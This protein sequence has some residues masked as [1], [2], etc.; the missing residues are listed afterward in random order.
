LQIYAKLNP[1][2]TGLRSLFLPVFSV[3]SDL[4]IVFL[5]DRPL[6]LAGEKL[7]FI[8][9]DYDRVVDA[10]LDTLRP[11]LLHGHLLVMNATPATVER[12]IGML[13]TE[14]VLDLLSVTL[15]CVDKLA[16]VTKLKSMFRMVKA[17]GG[18]VFKGEK[19]LLM[20]R[21]GVWDLPKGKLDP[22]ENSKTAAVREVAEE[23]G[24]AALLGEKI[25]TTYH[26]Y[27]H[28]G[29]A[30]LKRTKWFRM[31]LLDDSQ[32]M[33]QAE[34]GIEALR[35]LDYDAVQQALT[36]SFSS[37]RYVIEQTYQRG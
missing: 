12:L 24:V 29:Q 15:S 11:E 34:E 26:T 36:N 17:A 37:I 25:C 16:A 33:P 19:M 8:P 31:T 2:K 20:Y 21:R 3:F 13:Q 35:W 4:M 1:V 10:R 30:M 18:V 6:L 9:A 7:R 22:G 5:A 28:N 32:M 27:T 14:Y 23:T